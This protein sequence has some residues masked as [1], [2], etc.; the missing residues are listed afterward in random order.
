MN[1]ILLVAARNKNRL[2]LQSSQFLAQIQV[3]PE[4]YMLYI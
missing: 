4:L 1:L 2:G 3:R